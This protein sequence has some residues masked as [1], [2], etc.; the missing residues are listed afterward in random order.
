MELLREKT[1]LTT[2]GPSEEIAW[3]PEVL[4]G[5]EL[6]DGIPADLDLAEVWYWLHARLKA[7]GEMSHDDARLT[8]LLNWN[9]VTVSDAL[10]AARLH[11]SQEDAEN[12]AH[13]THLEFLTAEF[14]A[15]QVLEEESIPSPEL[16]PA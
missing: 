13:R 12:T 2:E 5:A 11:A 6:A 15:R 8:A 16:R 9:D 10:R 1:D 7:L 14:L 3:Q 4:D